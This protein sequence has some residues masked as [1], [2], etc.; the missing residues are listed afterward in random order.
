MKNETVVVYLFVG[1]IVAA[2]ALASVTFL[3]SHDLPL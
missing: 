2:A 1:I 3:I